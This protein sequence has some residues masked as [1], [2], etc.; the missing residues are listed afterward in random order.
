MT[1]HELARIL[2]NGPNLPVATHANN[3]DYFSKPSADGI[4]HGKLKVGLAH[5]YA[6]DHVIIGNLSKLNLNKPNWYVK[7]MLHGRCPEEWSW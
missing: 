3:H 5:H 7:K 4:S 2:L 6:G 1:A